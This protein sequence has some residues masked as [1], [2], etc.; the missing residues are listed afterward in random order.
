MIGESW[1]WHP[2]V[3]IVQA[4]TP[5][6]SRALGE[7]HLRCPA[8][9][10]RISDDRVGGTLQVISEVIAGTKS[11]DGSQALRTFISSSFLLHAL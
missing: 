5:C 2:D 4:A 11:P 6:L 1:H 10:V 7:L 3:L 8:P 9:V